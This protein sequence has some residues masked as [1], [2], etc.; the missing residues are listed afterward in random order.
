MVMD[1]DCTLLDDALFLR[2]T[3]MQVMRLG[4]GI[5]PE[6]PYV[7][8]SATSKC[9]LQ[10]LEKLA[11][12]LAHRYFEIDIVLASNTT[13]SLKNESIVEEDN[14]Y[15][16]EN[17]SD[18]QLIFLH[19]KAAAVITTCEDLTEIAHKINANVMLGA[20]ETL[21]SKIC[22]LMQEKGFNRKDTH[23]VSLDVDASY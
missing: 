8:F 2:K 19:T 15:A 12:E 21:F 22:V 1:F 17:L 9:D 10:T 23:S 11:I 3:Q 5:T 4:Y 6:R 18:E 7:L 20:Q 14:C 13:I 16:L